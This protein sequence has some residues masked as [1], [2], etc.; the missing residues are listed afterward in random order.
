MAS[1]SKLCPRGGLEPVKAIYLDFFNTELSESI[2]PKFAYVGGCTFSISEFFE[3][4]LPIKNTFDAKI[5]V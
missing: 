4:D 2:Y 3:C 1:T 5:S